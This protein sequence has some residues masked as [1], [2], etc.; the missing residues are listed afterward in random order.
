[1][2]IRRSSPISGKDIVLGTAM[3]GLGISLIGFGALGSFLMLSI[4]QHSI[5]LTPLSTTLV[6]LALA[7]FVA[8]L[9]VG[10]WAVFDLLRGRLGAIGRYG[11]IGC[12]A[13]FVA[14]ACWFLAA[15]LI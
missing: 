6:V 11:W 14:M 5:V 3:G 8:T 10:G 7:G 13:L 2:E 1:M 4:L 15:I 9:L 12:G